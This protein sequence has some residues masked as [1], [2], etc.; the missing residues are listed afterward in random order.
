MKLQKIRKAIW[1]LLIRLL[2]A[3]KPALGT[4]LAIRFYGGEGL[5][6]DGHPTFIAGDA[7][8][9]STQ[10]YGL[11]TFGEGVTVSARVTV[12]THDW[13]PSR[14]LWSLGRPVSD[15]PVGRLLPVTVKPY[16]FIGMGATLLPGC[17][18]GRAAVVGAGSVVR[19]TVPDYAIV[20][21]N[22]ATVVGDN[23]EYVARK[24]PDEWA[25]LPS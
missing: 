21:G 15:P 9:D 23:R 17:T 7:W 1:L 13:S 12:L 22:P 25:A 3:V 14:V 11:I 20:M 19:G 6:F 18:V 2:G 24:F 5:K 10:S 16:A 4:R 8:F